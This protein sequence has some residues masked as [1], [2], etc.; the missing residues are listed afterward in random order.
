MMNVGEMP[1]VDDSKEM[2]K[3]VHH[4]RQ[5]LQMCFDFS[6]VSLSSDH[7]HFNPPQKW[8]LKQVK[9]IITGW[10]TGLYDGGWWA[11]YLEK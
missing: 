3:Y 7:D 10:S 5:E 9:D 1:G 8:E 2:L 6:L 4:D 11:M